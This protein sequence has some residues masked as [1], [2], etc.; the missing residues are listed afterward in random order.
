MASWPVCASFLPAVSQGQGQVLCEAQW[1]HRI[2]SFSFLITWLQSQQVPVKM[3]ESLTEGGNASD[4]DGGRKGGGGRRRGGEEEEG[5]EEGR[6][7]IPKPAGEKENV[8]PAFPPNA[9]LFLLKVRIRPT[10]L[11]LT[12]LSAMLGKNVLF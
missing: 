2:G 12:S 3:T 11:C 6:V 9:T 7:M 1:G 4:P 5:M 10:L 8:L